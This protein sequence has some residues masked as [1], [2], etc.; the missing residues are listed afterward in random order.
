MNKLQTKGFTLIELIVVIAVIG[1]IAA[2]AAPMYINLVQDAKH[3]KLLAAQT[4]LHSSAYAING[5]YLASGGDPSKSND[6]L[7]LGDG[8]IVRIRYGFPRG[9]DI[10]NLTELD[11]YNIIS[12]IGRAD[13]RIKSD[14]RT[15]LRYRP[16]STGLYL[17]IRG[18]IENL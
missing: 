1:V 15:F 16:R 10:I 5:L 9:T 3:K 8:T 14:D 12:R 13:I 6:Q 4:A 11:G 18:R 17:Q 7:R 2:I